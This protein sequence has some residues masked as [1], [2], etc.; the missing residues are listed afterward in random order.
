MGREG[1]CC[2]TYS[3]YLEGENRRGH[4]KKNNCNP[5]IL[6]HSQARTSGRG[7]LLLEE[8]VLEVAGAASSEDLIHSLLVFFLLVIIVS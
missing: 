8:Y 4:V 3:G 1:R 6:T 2:S 5:K 7:S